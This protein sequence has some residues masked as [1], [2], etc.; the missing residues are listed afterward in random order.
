MGKLD[1]LAG[2]ILATGAHRG[3]A[4]VVVKDVDLLGAGH[5]FNQ[6]DN[7]RIIDRFDFFGVIKVFDRGFMRRKGDALLIE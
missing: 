4:H 7:L 6:L 2:A 5:F 1:R 3:A